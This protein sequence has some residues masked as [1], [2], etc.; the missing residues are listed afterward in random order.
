MVLMLVPFARS[1]SCQRPPG[2]RAT[3]FSP[4]QLRPDLRLASVAVLTG[5]DCVSIAGAHVG[6]LPGAEPRGTLSHRTTRVNRAVDRDSGGHERAY[7]RAAGG[8]AAAAV[9]T[10]P[11]GNECS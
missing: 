5:P 11:A 10:P 9:G 8:S 3:A 7:R 6:R 1:R 4:H 2:A